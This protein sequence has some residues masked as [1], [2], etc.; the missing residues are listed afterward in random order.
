MF[1]RAALL[2]NGVLKVAERVWLEAFT[3]A[4]HVLGVRLS[5]G[6]FASG[7]RTTSSSLNGPAGS[8]S[9]RDPPRD[10]CGGAQ[11][12]GL[13]PRCEAGD[14]P[15]RLT[16]VSV[17]WATQAARNLSTTG[18]TVM[19]SPSVSSDGPVSFVPRRYVPFLLP[20]SSSV[21]R[22]ADTTIR[23]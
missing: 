1:D 6:K 13:I 11:R 21:A 23:A 22:P 12:P 9:R 7:A 10:R 19:T 20:R 5:L 16:S 18:P 17:D 2:R 3:S 4:G 8:P 15:Q 14:P